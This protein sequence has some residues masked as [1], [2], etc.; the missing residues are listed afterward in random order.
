MP[1]SPKCMRW[2]AGTAVAAVLALAGACGDVKVATEPKLP[3]AALIAQLPLTVGVYYS[4]RF[5]N[6]VH[7]EDR[8]GSGYEINLGPGHVHLVDRLFNLEFKRTVPVANLSALPRNPPYSVILEPRIERYSFLT[9]RDTGGKYFAVTIGYRLN[10][11]NTKGERIDSLTFVGYGS[12]SSS[13]MTTKS[14]L[15]AATQAAMRDAAAKFLVQF[16]EQATVR[17]LV[18]GETVPPLGEAPTEVAGPARASGAIEVVPI[19]ERQPDPTP[20]GQGQGGA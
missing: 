13:G 9:S 20:A 17:K 11:Y 19:E 16:P 4:D 6:Y 1:I 12:D 10:L 5:R 15:E 18:A 8:W 2:T 7:R 3:P 14:P